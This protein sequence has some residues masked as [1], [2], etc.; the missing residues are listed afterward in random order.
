MT[1]RLI[2][3]GV[4][5]ALAGLN[6]R[7]QQ[8]SSTSSLLKGFKPLDS[9][10]GLNSLPSSNSKIPAVP[11]SKSG[12]NADTTEITATTEANFDQQTRKAVFIGS[13]HVKH[14]QFTLSSDRLTAFLKKEATATHPKSGDQTAGGKAPEASQAGGGKAPAAPQ[15]GGGLEKVIAEGSVVIIQDKPAADGGE[16]THYVAKAARAEYEDATGNVTLSGWPQVAQGINMQVATEESTVMILNRDGKMT[17]SGG[18]K[19]LIQDT[20]KNNP[21]P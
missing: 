15:P 1:N 16:P 2:C 13:V 9:G 8:E 20:E 14:P 5:L 7:G 3:F 19:T 12:A 11:R 21:H 18:S 17:T 4:V 6:A 10:N